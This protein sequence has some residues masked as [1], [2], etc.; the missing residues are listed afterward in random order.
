MVEVNLIPKFLDNAISP[1]ATSVGNTLTS[2]W[3]IVF[4]SVDFYS[5]KVEHKRMQNLM[6]FKQELEEKV[7]SLPEDKLVEPPLHIIGPTL[8]ASKYY[9][10][11]EELRSMFANL[12]A[13]SIN[14]DTVNNTHPS[15][16]EII[17]QINSDEAKIFKRIGSNG[18][19]LLDVDAT[20]ENHS[21]L[22]ILNNFSNIAEISNCDNPEFISSYLDNLSRLGLITIR[23]N[24]LKN[25]DLYTVLNNHPVIEEA[26]QNARLIGDKTPKVTKKHF[27]STPFGINFYHTCCVQ[28]ENIVLNQIEE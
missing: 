4:G 26:I 28:H 27:H 19:P 16:V 9:Y 13:S 24:P 12:I 23:D 1:V 8:E 6:Q 18:F 17:K 5:Q 14:V 21:F 11:N 25:N 22:T 2:M 10:E 15:Y 3:N 7:A 20:F